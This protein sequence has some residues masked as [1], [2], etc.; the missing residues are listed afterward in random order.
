MLSEICFSK[1]AVFIAG[2]KVSGLENINKF[3]MVILT[4]KIC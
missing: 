3:A 1:F 2:L 4:C